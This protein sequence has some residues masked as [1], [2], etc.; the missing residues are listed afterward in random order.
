VGPRTG[1]D[2]VER[3]KIVPLS[4]LEL[5]LLGRSARNQSLYRLRYPDRTTVI[6]VVIIII[7]IIMRW[8]GH[9]A[10]ME[11]RNACRILVGKPE[12]KRPL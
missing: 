3:R 5:G 11:T 4:G 8:A 12:G 6:I 1:L 2:D 7:I 10:R 9:V